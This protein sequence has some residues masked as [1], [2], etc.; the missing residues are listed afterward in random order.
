LGKDGADVKVEVDL[1]Q[2]GYLLRGRGGAGG[3][4]AGEEEKK[5]EVWAEGVHGS[6]FGDPP[7]NEMRRGLTTSTHCH[8][9]N[10]RYALNVFS[11]CVWF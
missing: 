9:H 11:L 8:P 1:A 3:S 7:K 5:K 4:A 10:S 2:G 6:R